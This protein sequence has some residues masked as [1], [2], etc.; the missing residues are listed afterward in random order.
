MSSEAYTLYGI[1]GGA[2]DV[3]IDL[4]I[5]LVVLLIFISAADYAAKWYLNEE[6][7]KMSTQ[8]IKDEQKNAEGDPKMKG[9]RMEM[10]RKLMESASIRE[11][12]NADVV[13][14]NPQHY[15]VALKYDGDTM[16]APLVIAKGVDAAAARIREVARK[17]YIPIIP[18]PPLA[19]ALYR[20]V[21]I[22]KEVPGDL[23]QAVALVLAQ[24][25]KGGR[26]GR[27]A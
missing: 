13:V 1:L 15:A 16:E 21:K 7:M 2:V 22:G 20:Q 23:Y 11:V 6:E 12:P 17:H 8:D 19:R 14:V 10:A 4:G 9:R 26:G 18:Q 3:C 27:A 5:R 24:V 25:Y